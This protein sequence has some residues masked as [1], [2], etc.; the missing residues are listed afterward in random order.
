M[1]TASLRLRPGR[2]DGITWLLD[3][4]KKRRFKGRTIYHYRQL[5]DDEELKALIQQDHQTW[6]DSFPDD[7]QDDI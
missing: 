7:E 2:D 3:L 4:T 1:A 5:A 6:L